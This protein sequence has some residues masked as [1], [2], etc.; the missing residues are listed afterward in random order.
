MNK[1]KF[2]LFLVVNLFFSLFAFSSC[3]D[4]PDQE[5]IYRS[6]NETQFASFADSVDYKKVSV[7]GLYGDNFVYMK[8]IEKAN[9][10]SPMPIYTSEVKMRY[11][12]YILTRWTN[13]SATA[14][15]FDTNSEKEVLKSSPL[16]TNIIGVAIA[17]QNMRV[18][19]HIH[20][21][22]PWYLAYGADKTVGVRPY[23]SL[24]FDIKLEEIVK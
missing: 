20:V 23:T 10:A 13:N 2:Y 17:L 21:A 9:E 22:V 24:F 5:L 8:Y 15:P 14:L 4:E 3:N 19:D 18:G 11:K 7:P 6:N 12:A 1:M 16:A